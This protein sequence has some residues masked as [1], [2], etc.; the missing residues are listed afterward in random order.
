MMTITS[1]DKQLNEQLQLFLPWL[2]RLRGSTSRTH[3]SDVLGPAAAVC[4]RHA[5]LRRG[6]CLGVGRAAECKPMGCVELPHAGGRNLTG[7]AGV[8]V[9]SE[10]ASSVHAAAFE[11]R[12]VDVDIS[13]VHSAFSPEAIGTGKREYVELQIHEAMYR[14]NLTCSVD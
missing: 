6:L 2:G 11:N 4:R 14:A 10:T 5:A 3:G 9:T 7:R 8:A 12:S 1:Y 13:A